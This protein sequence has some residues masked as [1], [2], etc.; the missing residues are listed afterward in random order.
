MSGGD[1]RR[2]VAA[3]LGLTLWVRRRPAGSPCPPAAALSTGG[4]EAPSPPPAALPEPGGPASDPGS[5]PAAEWAALEREVAS[6]TRCA[7]AAGRTRTVFGVGDRNARWLLVGE[8]PG[9]DEDLQ[10]EPFVG[11]AGRL[12]DCMLAA[13]GLSRER[14]FIANVVKCRPPENR[15]PLDDECRACLPY[16]ERQIALVRP[17]LVL[18]LG[19]VAAQNILRTNASL[20]ALRGRVLRYEGPVE[21]AVV[22]TY[23]PAYLLRQPSAKAEAW[24]DLKLAARSVAP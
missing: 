17:S 16:L 20:G 13:L 3:E 6:C 1:P 2:A 12:L 4:A 23:H 8:G 15:T 18:A 14:V 24:R 11:R 22:V 21:S 19:R 5:G 10:G 9:R 7:L